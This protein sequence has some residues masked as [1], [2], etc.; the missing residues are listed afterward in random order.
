MKVTC[1]YYG[2]D[3]KWKCPSCGQKN[4]VDQFDREKTDI[5]IQECWNCGKEFEPVYRMIRGRKL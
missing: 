3:L 2:E 5:Y 1:R 4:N